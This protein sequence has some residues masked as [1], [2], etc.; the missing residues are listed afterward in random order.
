MAE[1][2]AA[3]AADARFRVR[4]MDVEALNLPDASCDAVIANWMLYHVV[5]L[6]ATIGLGCA[7]AC[8][9]RRVMPATAALHLQGALPVFSGWRPGR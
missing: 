8:S 2:E 6:A 4:Q 3:L 5:P 9:G 7:D 1:A